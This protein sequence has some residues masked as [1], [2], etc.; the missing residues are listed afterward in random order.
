MARART[1]AWL[2]RRPDGVRLAIKVTPRATRA[3]VRGVEL[4]AAGE[5]HLAVRVGAP[6]DGGKA[7]A[8]AIRLLAKRWGLA[9][10][11][12]HLVSGATARRKVLHVAGAP[13]EL[14]TRLEAAEQGEGGTVA[15]MAEREEA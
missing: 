4:D 2:T 7:N 9:P 15:R 3:G 8:E 13:D 11:D 1:P 14:I 5:A 10:R 6:P 12:V